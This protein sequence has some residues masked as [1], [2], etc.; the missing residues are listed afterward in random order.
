[1]EYW[2]LNEHKE[3]VKVKDVLTWGKYFENQKRRIVMQENLTVRSN[4]WSVW[5]VKRKYWISTV[6]LGI[7]HQ[8]GTGPPL[9][10]ETMVFTG[11]DE[12]YEDYTE[13]CSTWKEA[14]QQH[15]KVLNEIRQSNL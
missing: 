11:D 3:C 14:I 6:F 2:I 12:D 7:D 10:F 1:M 5:E 8:W 9:L 4:K 13:R 15:K